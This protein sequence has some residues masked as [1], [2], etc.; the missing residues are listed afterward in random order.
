MQN[1]VFFDKEGNSLNFTYNESL[2]R[3]EGDILFPVGSSD[4]FKT[5]SLYVFENID[6]FVFENPPDLSLRKWQLFNEY[7][8]HF[9]SGAATQSVTKIEPV[10]FE[11]TFYSKWI[12]S[13]NIERNFKLG[14]FVR[15]NTP[16]F[17]FNEPNIV[18]PVVGSKK[19]AILILS[20][21]NN[22]DFESAFSGS[23]NDG[24]SYGGVTVT[25]TDLIGIYNYITPKLKDTL[26]IWNEPTF[27][28]RLYQYRKINIVNTDKNDNYRLTGKYQDVEV[29]TIKNPSVQDIVHHEWRLSK[30]S[31]PHDSQLIIEVLSKTDLPRV[32]KGGLSFDSTNNRLYFSNNIPDIL[33]PGT[34]FKVTN[35]VLNPYFFKVSS[36]PTF[37]SIV[38]LTYFATGSQV[39]YENVLYECIQA[40]TWSAVPFESVGIF[41]YSNDIIPQFSLGDSTSFLPGPSG[42]EES[43]LYWS[44][45]TYLPIEPSSLSGAVNDEFLTGGEIYLT[46]DRL[47]FTQSFTQSAEVTLASAAERFKSEMKILNIDFYYEDTFLK[48]D[49]IYPSKYAIVNYYYNEVSPTYSIGSEDRVYEKLIETY[50]SL[51]KEFNYNYSSNWDYNIVF[52]DID[53][54]GIIIKINK[55]PYKERISYVYSSGL[56]DMQR[57]IDKTLRNWLTRHFMPLSKLGILVSLNTVGFASVYYNSINLKSDFPNVR[58]DFTVG[59]GITADYYIEHSVVIFNTIGKNLTIN[60]NGRTYEEQSITDTFT[61]QID[62]AQTLANWTTTWAET[63][64]DFGIFVTNAASALRFN[65]K[66]QTQR[67][68]LKI[69]TNSSTL[70]GIDSYRILKKFSGNLGALLTSNEIVMATASASFEEKG[71]ATG[72]VIGINNTYYPLQNIQYNS[73]Y[74]NPDVINLSY[75]GPFWGLTDSLCN[76]SPFTTVAFNLGFEQTGCSPSFVPSLLQGMYDKLAFTQSFSIEYMFTNTYFNLELSGIAEMVD[77]VYVEPVNSIYV[78]GDRVTVFNSNYANSATG[79]A[80]AK[81]ATAKASET[82]ATKATRTAATGDITISGLTQSI[83]LCYNHVSSYLWALSK[84]S[85]YKIDPYVNVLTDIYTFSSTAYSI[86]LNNNNGDIYV[87]FENSS[88]LLIYPVSGTIPVTVDINPYLSYNMVFNDFENDMY[89][90]TDAAAV[91]RIDGDTRDWQATYSVYVGTHSIAYDPENEAVYVMSSGT[92]LKKIDNNAVVNIP[93]VSTGTFDN[94]LFNNLTSTINISSDTQFNSVLVDTDVV[95]FTV[96]PPDYGY[97][98]LNQ[99]DGDI[100]IGANSQV[101][102]LDS[103]SGQTKGLQ[104]FAGGQ[105]TKLV[106]NP[107]RR[108]IWGIQPD[109]QKVI[110]I[111]VELG[112]YFNLDSFTGSTT[113]NL[114]GTLSPE[115]NKKDYLWLNV[116]EYIRRPRANFNEDPQVSFYWKWFSDNVQQFFLYDFS[117]SQLSTSGALAYTGPKPLPTVFLN[118][119][120]NRDPS[121]VKDPEYQQTIFSRVDY[122]LEYID[123][124]EDISV[125]PEPL[126]VFIGYNSLDEGALRSIL[127]LYR[128]E[129]IDFTITTNSSNNDVILFQTLQDTITGEIF[130]KISLKSD[131]SSFFTVTSTGTKR[132]LRKGQTIAIF[133]KDVSNQK[134]QYISQN[135]GY[136]LKIKEV[137]SREIIVSFFKE[138][139]FLVQ[140][141]TLINNFPKTGLVT[142]LSLRI[143]VWDKE[144][145]RFNVLGQT[146]IEDIRYHT[147]LN[148]VGKLI[149][150]DDVYIFKEYDIKEEGIDWEYLNM[151][152]K[153]MLMVKNMIYPYIGS[154]KSII[155]AINYFGYNDLELSEYYRNINSNSE[156]FGKLFKVEIPDIFDNSVAGWTENNFIKHLFP[157]KNYTDTN[158]FNLTYRITDK[159][160]NNILY[161]TL[162]EVQKKLQGLKYWLQKNII[163]ITH[164][165]LDITGRADFND[166]TVVTHITRDAQ[167]FNI[168]QNFTPVMFDM[169]ETYLLPVNSG[170]TV[171]NCVLDFYIL[172]GTSS[173]LPDSYTVDIRTYEIYREWYAFRN[174]QKG[175]RVVYYNKLYESVIPN[176]KTNN[177]RKFENIKLWNSGTVYQ[178]GDVAKYDSLIY[179]WSGQAGATYSSISPAIDAGVGKN[180]VDVTEWKQ[181]SLV[182]VDKISEYRHITNLKPFNFTVDSNITPYLVIEVTSDNGYGAIYRDRK[183]FE[184]R[185]I[186]D[187]QEIEAFSNL[188]TKQYR[189]ATLPVVYA[190][191]DKVPNLQLVANTFTKSFTDMFGRPTDRPYLATSGNIVFPNIKHGF[192]FIVQNN[193]SFAV[194]KFSIQL[195]DDFV[196]MKNPYVLVNSG[197]MNI[198]GKNLNWSGNLAPGATLSLEVRADV[199]VGGKSYWVDPINTTNNQALVPVTYSVLAKLLTGSN[200]GMSASIYGDL[201]PQYFRLNNSNPQFTAGT[202]PVFVT[203]SFDSIPAFSKYNQTFIL[204]TFSQY[205]VNLITASDSVIG[206]THFGLVTEIF[207]NAMDSFGYVYYQTR[208]SSTQW[209]AR[210]LLSTYYQDISTTQSYIQRIWD[211]GAQTYGPSI[212]SDSFGFGTNSSIGSLTITQSYYP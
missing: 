19:D 80:T 120:P 128:S 64:N 86:S 66:K 186:L 11:Q 146:E 100:Y 212:I 2:E 203:Q 28:D 116:R 50:E 195:G 69:Q 197:V 10:N 4:T 155:N 126:Q 182:P 131:S 162:E 193:S 149:S 82:S 54:S 127:Q 92:N 21:L 145:G 192:P 137:Y 73:L 125:V 45:P 51:V 144:I 157:N 194:N 53:E 96:N 209:Q 38:N 151:K 152:R 24:N 171:Y 76:K 33:S 170:S 78:L 156:N 7:G 46:T 42:S 210:F 112:S 58:I 35:S 105:I 26:S 180:W 172:P 123:D 133:V 189:D 140:E 22:A 91:L 158:L 13:K 17:E 174:Y 62:I 143:I 83:A 190:D 200:Y 94:L 201:N 185:G 206:S 9:Y 117:G 178:V 148:N 18:Y 36:I 154:Y 129:N 205:G 147:E 90:T 150:S 49:L 85:L 166:N 160:G 202:I 5:Q 60:I 68:D 141:Q 118:N 71:F 124:N 175:E 84:N 168:H 153:E 114:Y 72:Q 75:E 136:L 37:E 115:Y 6:A 179:V 12:Y 119:K 95:L 176:N 183:N 3:H 34:E 40:Y 88:D 89:V 57:T 211:L 204:S 101:I 30:N 55:N 130:G 79:T 87:S 39:L 196:F 106:Y 121:K 41:N 163:P 107:D 207:N 23:Y 77:I 97:Q 32:Y 16:I 142:Y 93:S 103:L 135:N 56:V 8:F 98:A 67:V 81:T 15:F 139:D 104:T 122:N 188:T 65:V 111:S 110:E 173:L 184:I 113:E 74:L 43:G 47:Y 70:P 31:L 191:V 134:S 48:A 132:G 159:E 102:I 187:I 52:V 208:V 177:P 14:T 25:G 59:V 99:F 63:V 109:T 1:L 198:Q 161:Y 199:T 44:T 29:V 108:S 20:N 165:I 138:V 167:I 181:I 27:Y 164:K 61:G 169:N